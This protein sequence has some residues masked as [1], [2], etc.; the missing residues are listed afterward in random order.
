MPFLTGDPEIAALMIAILCQRMRQTSEQLEDALLLDAPARLARC[1]LR[2]GSALGAP[3]GAGMRLN[4][5]L[6]QQQIGS[7]IGISREITNK[8]IVEWTRTGYLTTANG[9]LRIV[10]PEALRAL[11]ETEV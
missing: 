6:S 8:Y 5:K 9:F 4:I 11:S 2:L 7:L 3:D 1:L 10:D